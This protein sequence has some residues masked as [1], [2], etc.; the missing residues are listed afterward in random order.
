MFRALFAATFAFFLTYHPT[1]LAAEPGVDKP[2]PVTVYVARKVIT[3]EPGLPDATAVAVAEGRIVGVGSEDSLQS[4]IDQRGGSVD[5]T[6]ADKILM[7]AGL[8]QCT[9][10]QRKSL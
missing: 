10:M 2:A 5:K 4:W 7:P 9:K 1:V 6:F 8:G 3:M